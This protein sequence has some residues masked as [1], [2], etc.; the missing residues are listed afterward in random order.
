MCS[1]DIIEFL[2]IVLSCEILE[3]YGTIETM[4]TCF[5]SYPG[6]KKTGHVGGPLPGIYAK[7]KKMPE[8]NLLEYSNSM[9]GELCIKSQKLFSKYYLD[10]NTKIDEDGWLHTKDVFIINPD[11]NSFKFVDIKMCLVRLSNGITI[12]LQKLES[13]YKTSKFVDQIF[14]TLKN[15][16]LIGIVVPCRGFVIGKLGI[17][18]FSQ[19]FENNTLLNEVLN[20]FERIG[21]RF[22]LKAYEKLKKVYLEPEPLA[23]DEVLSP[24]LRLRRLKIEKKYA[25]VLQQLSE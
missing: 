20:D 9:I 1:S 7:L 13:V 22:E 12:S 8:L 21:V 14:I 5:C 6:D 23:S 2:R 18:E 3:G 10:F 16:C 4:I 11:N 25:N 19:A 17:E 24:T 15:S